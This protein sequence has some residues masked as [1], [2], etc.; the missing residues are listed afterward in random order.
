[1]NEQMQPLQPKNTALSMWV[2]RY[3]G[4]F[5]LREMRSTNSRLNNTEVVYPPSDITQLEVERRNYFMHIQRMGF[6]YKLY[7]LGWKHGSLKCFSLL[8]H[9][10]LSIFLYYRQ[11]YRQGSQWKQHCLTSLFTE[12][13]LYSDL[14][15]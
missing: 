6:L 8:Q 1:M 9:W 12:M 5:Y 10:L 4:V 3:R 7:C 14:D 2:L 11:G 15:S 13:K